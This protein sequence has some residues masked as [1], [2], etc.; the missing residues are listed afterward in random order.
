M[1][2]N[3]IQKGNYDSNNELSGGGVDLIQLAGL[4]LRIDHLHPFLDC[5][6]Y[7]LI[8]KKKSTIDNQNCP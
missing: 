5:F 8:N 1:K 7:L 3:S 6:T 4:G 2:S